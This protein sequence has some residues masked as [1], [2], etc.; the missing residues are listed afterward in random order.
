MELD[1][2]LVVR[3]KRGEAKAQEELVALLAPMVFRLA[4]LSSLL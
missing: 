4:G 1:R 3:A 2:E